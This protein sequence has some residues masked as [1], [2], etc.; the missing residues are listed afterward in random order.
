M[1]LPAM[2]VITANAVAFPTLALK[3]LQNRFR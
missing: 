3:R 2:V 1:A